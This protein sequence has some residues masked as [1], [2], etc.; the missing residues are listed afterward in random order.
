MS[1]ASKRGRRP[2]G[3]TRVLGPGRVEARIHIDE[4][5]Y[6][7]IFVD[8]RDADDWITSLID[9]SPGKRA[10]LARTREL[11]L[12]QAMLHR[13]DLKLRKTNEDQLKA[14]HRLIRDFP[15]LCATSLYRIDETDIQ[16]F[17]D[18]RLDQDVSAATVN[19]DLAMIGNTFNLARTKMKCRALQNPIGPTTRLPEPPG[20]A[21][22]LEPEEE[23]ILLERSAVHEVASS[24]P[25]GDII[26]FAADSA[27]RLGEIANM[28]WEHFDLN[29]GTLHI[30]KTKNGAPRTIPLWIDARRI[31]IAQSPQRSGSIWPGKEAIRS[32]WRSVRKAAITQAETAGRCELAEGLRDFRF[33]DLRHEG[34]SRLIERTNWENA[35]LKAVTGHKTDSMLGRYSHLRGSTLA[36]EMAEL[37]GSSKSGGASAEDVSNNQ[38]AEICQSLHQR[39][40]WK[41][42][43]RDPDVLQLLVDSKPITSIASSYGVSD[44]AVH[45]ACS[46]HGIRKKPPGWWAQHRSAH[47]HAEQTVR[48]AS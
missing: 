34:T 3:S 7:Q 47:L 1:K 29:D 23:A 14:T 21:R 12:G 38:P 42:V 43:S 9:A 27:M 16:N 36:K 45:K 2:T 18:E 4:Q 33:H 39:T 30:P 10:E 15:T 40:L 17:I 19:R 46:K 28:R 11:T 24:V 25:I 31:L 20:R 8:R 22:R 48:G 37:D 41:A 6:R 13:I 35:K 5:P 26:R 44:S 32:A